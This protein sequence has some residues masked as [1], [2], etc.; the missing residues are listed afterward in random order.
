MQYRPALLPR[1]P[2]SDDCFGYSV[3][4]RIHGVVIGVRVHGIWG[5]ALPKLFMLDIFDRQMNSL[6]RL[7]PLGVRIQFTTLHLG[8]GSD[9]YHRGHAVLEH[10]LPTGGI[11]PLGTAHPPQ[12]ISDL[13][14]VPGPG[15]ICWMKILHY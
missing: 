8:W 12:P 10:L 5:I 9:V 7:G 4:E 2:N 13:P 1:I 15:P 14:G 6:N 3:P 11:N